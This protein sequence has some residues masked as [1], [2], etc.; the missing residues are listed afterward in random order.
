LLDGYGQNVDFDF[1]NTSAAAFGQ[2]EFAL[3]NRLKLTPGLRLNYDKKKLDYD[4]QVY[5]GLQTSDPALIAL[6]RSILSP[7]TYQANAGDGNLSGQL[8]LSYS[9][10]ENIHTYATY[11]T[12]FKSVGLNLGGVPIDGAGNAV[13]AAAI[14]KPERV[15]TLEFGVK[16]QPL[17][18]VTANLA[19]FNTA[20][21]DFQTQV[22]NAQVGVLRG[23]LANASKVRVRGAEFDTNASLN[24]HFS[25]YAAAAFTE[26]KYISFPDAPPPLEETGGPQVK[27]IAGGVLPG[28]SRWAFSWG[29][30]AVNPGTLFGQPGQIF[31]RVDASYRSAFSSS[32]SPSRF[33]DI[34]AYALLNAQFGFRTTD[35]WS[36]SV[37]GRNLLNRNYFELLSGAPGNSGLYE[38]LPG[39]PRTLG[40]T[41]KKTI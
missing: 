25:I 31:G 3:T 20:I 2:V 32:P 9:A 38:G 26:G 24:E 34:G 15:R 5:G 41:L 35:R 40:L 13:V 28:I 29:G 16:S 37:W 21:R 39:D 23:Y 14:V 11:G 17:T 18:S 33:L 22:V 12:G 8:T 6:Q 30:E 7:L 36:I 10:A 19:V 27:D 4:Q 1:R